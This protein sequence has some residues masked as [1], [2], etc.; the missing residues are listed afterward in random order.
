VS[1][2]EGNTEAPDTAFVFTVTRT[3][4]T[5][6]SS[7]AKWAVSGLAQGS[8][9]D[10]VDFGGY[11]PSGTV[12]FTGGQVTEKITVMVLADVAGELDE[13][14]VVTLSEPTNADLLDERVATSLIVNDDTMVS[15]QAVA[16]SG[17]EGDEGTNTP[18]SFVLTR[19][20]NTAVASSIQWRVQGVSTDQVGPGDFVSG[21]DVLSNDGL[22]SG[23]VSFTAGQTSA[24]LLIQVDGDP[25]HA[26][27]ESFRVTLSQPSQGG[28]R[29]GPATFTI[30][31]DDALVSLATNAPG[32]SL[33]ASEGGTFVFPLLRSGTGAA[34]S[35]TVVVGWTLAGTGENAASAADFAGGVTSG[36]VTF[37]AGVTDAAVTIQALTD[38]LVER[39]EQFVLRLVQVP[40]GNASLHPL[41]FQA[42]GA[43]TDEDVGV[44]VTA[45]RSE[46]VEG[47]QLNGQT[48]FV[49]EVH[50]TGRT[51][52]ATVVDLEVSG[53]TGSAATADDFVSTLVGVTFA[54]GSN[55]SQLVTLG[56]VHDAGSEADETFV[57]GIAQGAGHTVIGAPV[58]GTIVSDDGTAGNDV[59]YGSAGDDLLR[60]GAGNDTLFGHG[61]QDRFVFEAPAQGVDSV[62][63]FAADDR[64]LVVSSAFGGLT[65]PAGA[66]RDLAGDLDAI[67]Q[68]LSG[69]SGSGG[70]ADP[71]FLRINVNGE[72]QFTTG[73]AGD[74]DELEAAITGGSASGPGFVAVTDGSAAVHLYYDADMGA[75]TDGSG[76]QPVAVLN[77]LSDAHLLQLQPTS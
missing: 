39:D 41:A 24:T 30:V 62:M 17:L 68:E 71:D 74:L 59:L 32:A 65:L 34:L 19:E 48:P 38:T 49:V 72:F 57:V 50:R 77:G 35:S 28:V 76:L 22:P 73:G 15:I 58:H 18:V 31:N 36:L 46:V 23:V 51:D 43:I 21:Q 37:A 61:G 7:S 33:I 11:L 64:V 47:S 53:G 25:D 44:W 40:S 75:G 55:A 45:L 27:D 2:A 4:S 70:S 66:T 63:D 3:G 67:L 20:G 26:A 14:F 9:V 10:P 6:G 54:A 1:K 29:G 5:V 8:T 69:G 16:A 13:G 12:I 52:Q 42:P 56:I 60:G